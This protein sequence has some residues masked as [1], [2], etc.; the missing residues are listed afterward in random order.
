MVVR[1][2][3]PW[4]TSTKSDFI[5]VGSYKLFLS[6]S[7]PP[8][9]HGQPVIIYFT[10]GGA[11]SIVYMRLQENLSE[12]TRTYF[13]DRAGYNNS[14]RGP[15]EWVTTQRSA[16]ELR[17]LMRAVN[18]EPPY[19]IVSHSYGSIVARSFLELYPN[20]V[21]GAVL[22]D[23]ATELMFELYPSVPCEELKVIGTNVDF[24][25]V[26]HLKE[27]SHLSD[28]EWAA[29]IKAIS[30]TTQGAGAEDNRG[31]GTWLAQ[32]QE[33]QRQVMADK[34]LSVIKCNAADKDY[35][36]IYEHGVKM[37]NG[38][39]EER[40]R[41]QKFIDSYRIFDD[42][43]K[44]AQLRLSRNSRYVVI[45]C[46]GHDMPIRRPQLVAKEVKWV[47][48]QLRYRKNSLHHSAS[49]VESR[50]MFAQPARIS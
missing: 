10:G 47:L 40:E 31:S 45:D 21:A 25:E 41:A 24:A 50:E 30:R 34:P 35:K 44:A 38:T 46:Y 15:D 7:G 9:K 27:E 28:N 17:A 22:I 6:T 5:S 23:S 8:R 16:Q 48:E 33:M 36:V 29:I 19:I 37:G 3:N 32:R 49:A 42:Q 39:K 43:I 4:E 13:Y 12:F 14:D 26:T 11:P 2:E 20:T 18:V 1:S